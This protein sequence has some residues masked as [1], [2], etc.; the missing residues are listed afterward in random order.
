MDSTIRSFDSYDTN[1]KTIDENDDGIPEMECCDGPCGKLTNISNLIEYKDCHHVFCANCAVNEDKEKHAKC[2]KLNVSTIS[3]QSSDSFISANSSAESS[4]VDILKFEF[5]NIV[6][7]VDCS[8]LTY[9]QLLLKLAELFGIPRKKCIYLTWNTEILGSH[10]EDKEVHKIARDELVTE[11][12]IS[13][14]II[15]EIHVD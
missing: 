10:E 4:T 11:L 12:S 9:G 1:D 7:T 3:T 2:Q 15:I 13:N 14:K 8:E 5:K 6:K